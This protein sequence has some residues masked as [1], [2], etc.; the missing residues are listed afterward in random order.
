[1]NYTN[2]AGAPN[3]TDVTLVVKIPVA[4]AVAARTRVQGGDAAAA[5]VLEH[6][7]AVCHAIRYTLL[8]DLNANASDANL[9]AAVA[10]MWTTI[11]AV[12]NGVDA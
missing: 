10:A 8:V 6:L 11:Q 2:A 12:A 7:D 9:D 5:K 4:V 3:G 1:M